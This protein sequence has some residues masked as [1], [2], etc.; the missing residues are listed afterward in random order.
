MKS[1]FTWL[2][3]S[4]ANPENTSATLKGILTI[5]A[6]KLLSILAALCGFGLLCMGIDASWLQS[7]IE[8]VQQV[9]LGGLYLVGASVAAYGLYRKVKLG[10]FSAYTPPTEVGI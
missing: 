2:V 3:T 10:Q 5:G 4:S 6:G 8:V 7:A 1:L 9:A